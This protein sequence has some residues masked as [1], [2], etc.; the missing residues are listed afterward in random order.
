ML[1]FIK[2][3]F[4]YFYFPLAL[5][6]YIY[7]HAL[8]IS[9]NPALPEPDQPPKLYS[10]EC[11]VDLRLA[12]LKA[13]KKAD[14][15]IHLVMFGLTEPSLL[16][17]IARKADNECVLTD[18]Y[19]DPTAS[20]P[21]THR[22][23]NLRPHPVYSSGLMHQKILVID[24]ELS[25][26]GSANMTRPSL[27]MH[28][29]LVVGLYSPKV[30]KFLKEKTPHSSGYLKT[31]VGGQRVEIWLLP[32]PRGHALSSIK[33]LIRSARQSIKVAMFTFTHPLLT[34][35][36]ID[37]KKAGVDVTVIID[38][39]AGIGSSSN[40][41]HR[42]KEAGIEILLSRGPQLMHHK[43]LYIDEKT[44]V[45]GSANWTK[46]AFYKNHDCFV[47]LHNVTEEQREF[48]NTLIRAVEL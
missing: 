32:D 30:A 10:N 22:I 1:K 16:R 2:K 9:L 35:E 24:K 4:F 39:N 31:M 40:T 12:L 28:N 33:S 42:L 19:Y 8:I 29:N 17:T 34:S 27:E 21:L 36:L 43:F 45:L 3:K 38:Y 7:L 25:F 23:A 26:L 20:I 48:M 46:S 5:L 41:V 47:T 11:K 44:L 37:A 14:K 13:I 18:I 15:E 6:L